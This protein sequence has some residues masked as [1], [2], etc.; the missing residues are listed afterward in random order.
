LD[1]LSFIFAII[2]AASSVA[3][4]HILVI[5]VT[6]Q[7]Y[8]PKPIMEKLGKP[9]YIKFIVEENKITVEAV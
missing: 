5:K 1:L 3:T 2:S 6:R 7:C 9:T 8:I 4:L